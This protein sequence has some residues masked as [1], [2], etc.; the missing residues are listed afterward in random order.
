[1]NTLTDREIV[2]RFESLM[3]TIAKEVAD[4]IWSQITMS[5]KMACGMRDLGYGEIGQ[6]PFLKMKVTIKPATNN[7]LIIFLDASDTYTVELIKIRAGKVTIQSSLN[8]IYVGN[9]NEVIYSICNQ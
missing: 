3:N 8:D 7:H 6:R 4:T 5:N 9:L 1:M 2:E